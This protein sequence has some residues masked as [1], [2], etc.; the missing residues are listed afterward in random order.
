MTDFRRVSLTGSLSQRQGSLGCV[1]QFFHPPTDCQTGKK[2]T[3]VLGK[4]VFAWWPLVPRSDKYSS[5]ELASQVQ[6]QGD[7]VRVFVC[8]CCCF[9]LKPSTAE[10]LR[11]ARHCAEQ[12]T[13]ITSFDPT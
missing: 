5:V 11:C 9:P 4:E 2:V 1:S 7:R 3:T 8:L 13:C 12:S 10:N 6:E